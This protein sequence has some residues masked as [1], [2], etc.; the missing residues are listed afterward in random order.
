VNYDRA[1]K[2]CR[3]ASTN[4]PLASKALCNKTRL[5]R[6]QVPGTTQ[7]MI[8][9]IDLELFGKVILTWQP[10]GNLVLSSCGYKTV[11]TKDRYARY[12]PQG[13]RVWQDRPYWYLS[14]PS[15]TRI[16]HDDMEV[17]AC[18]EDLHRSDEFNQLDAHDLYAQV[19]E[20]AKLYANELV[21]GRLTNSR[22]IDVCGECVRLNI[23]PPTALEMDIAQQNHLL[24]H[25]RTKDLVPGFALAAV[26]RTSSPAKPVW[27]MSDGKNDR[28]MTRSF[29]RQVIEAS[30]KESQVLWR[31]PKT[32]RALIDQTEALMTREDLPRLDLRP[33]YYRKN[34]QMLIE[35]FLLETFGYERMEDK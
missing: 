24:S 20:Y 10:D 30:W 32:K 27:L 17:N 18:G 31:K 12:L 1:E 26:S 7:D 21:A 19:L 2:T 15:G 14:T 13:F 4:K 35:D 34:L 25:L 5:V 11:T 6:R 3:H 8:D 23:S 28:Y 29:L 16:F 22:A 33:R 9:Y